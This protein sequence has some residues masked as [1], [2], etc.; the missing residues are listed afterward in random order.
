M[1]EIAKDR[2]NRTEIMAV[3][4]VEDGAM[5]HWKRHGRALRPRS[6]NWLLSRRS[7]SPIS[8]YRCTHLA[9]L[10]RISVYGVHTNRSTM[11]ARAPLAKRSRDPRKLSANELMLREWDNS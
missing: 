4:F 2:G 11:G 1:N 6:R 9:L 7:V 10:V 5:V 8:G 3:S